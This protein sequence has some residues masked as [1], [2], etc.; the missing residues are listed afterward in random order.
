MGSIVMGEEDDHEL[1]YGTVTREHPE[2]K[3]WSKTRIC[4]E[5]KNNPG[6]YGDACLGVSKL[7][8][9]EMQ[10]GIPARNTDFSSVWSGF[11]V[12]GTHLG[13]YE[14]PGTQEYTFAI[15]NEGLGRGI[16]P[17][18]LTWDEIP[19]VEKLRATTDQMSKN[20]TKTSQWI[21]GVT[22]QDCVFPA[23]W[24][25]SA[26]PYPLMD[27]GYRQLFWSK[28]EGGKSVTRRSGPFR[29]GRSFNP[30]LEPL[31]LPQ[32]IYILSDCGQSIFA[33]VLWE[34]LT[35]WRVERNHYI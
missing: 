17:K 16:K 20:P 30:P 31:T 4:L 19:D 11:K 23:D 7:A 1:E 21:G 18:C 2:A 6:Y 15:M 3:K 12:I 28:T 5:K 14:R 26:A 33:V 29:F 10:R 9:V 13:D 8:R 32:C 35:D 22:L 25:G 27:M 24:K 34:Y